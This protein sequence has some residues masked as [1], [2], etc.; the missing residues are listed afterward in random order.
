M[1]LQICESIF[2]KNNKFSE[3]NVFKSAN[4]DGNK[5]L[6]LDYASFSSFIK[7]FSKRRKIW[8]EIQKNIKPNPQLIQENQTINS[9][10]QPQ[11]VPIAKQ[12]PQVETQNIKQLTSNEAHQQTDKRETKANFSAAFSR[13]L[14]NE[15]FISE[16]ADNSNKSLGTSQYVPIK[17]RLDMQKFQLITLD[18]LE[19]VIKFGDL[20]EKLAK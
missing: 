9:P 16:L 4:I 7:I 17:A 2:L 13:I 14:P 15:I 11:V 10:P 5:L 19:M 8:D 3:A 20:V 1:F 18:P 12:D 6:Q